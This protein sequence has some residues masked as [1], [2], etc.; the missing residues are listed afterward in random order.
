MKKTSK[1]VCL[2]HRK[3]HRG[4]CPDCAAMKPLRTPVVTMRELKREQA[5]EAAAI[6]AQVRL[7]QAACR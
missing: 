7:A 5:A 1:L 6:M 4:K 2:L 3:P